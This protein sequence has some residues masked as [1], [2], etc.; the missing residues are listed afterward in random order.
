MF[1]ISIITGILICACTCNIIKVSSFI[2][3]IDEGKICVQCGRRMDCVTQKECRI[4]DNIYGNRWMLF[5]YLKECKRCSYICSQPIKW[6]ILF[7]GLFYM[8]YIATV[9]LTP[10]N[11]VGILYGIVAIAL[12]YL[13]IIDWNTQYIPLEMNGIIFL[14]GLIRLVA[15][16][17]NWLEYILGFFL[18]SGFLYV[19]NKVATPVLR[20]KYEDDTIEDVIGDGDMKLMAATGLLLGWKLNFIALGI[21]CVMGSVI[22][23]ILM[24]I[25]GS[26]H[27]LAFGPY[28]SLGVYITMICGEQLVSW[29]LNFLG[30]KPL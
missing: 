22:H 29:Y 10:D 7:F 26:G 5:S 6:N 23:L 16:R 12:L 19:V 30:V 3:M 28:L 25:K 24:K 18:V 11:L 13:G 15:D 4:G 8:V 9:F 20:R 27:R 21:G 1:W 17:S 14:C 2:D